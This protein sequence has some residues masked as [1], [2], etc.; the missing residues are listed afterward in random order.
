MRV[1]LL[2]LFSILQKFLSQH[3]IVVLPG[4]RRQQARNR[5]WL[6]RQRDLETALPV[7]PLQLQ[8]LA[9]RVAQPYVEVLQVGWAIPNDRCKA[10][11][12]V[13][14]EDHT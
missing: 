4:V 8:L 14:V 3:R 10:A 12:T 7:Q 5:C 11:A 1:W 2:V 9:V 6:R 13:L